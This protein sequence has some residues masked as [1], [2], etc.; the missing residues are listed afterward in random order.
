VLPT[1]QEPAPEAPPTRVNREQLGRSRGGLTPKI[2]LSSDGRARPL[3]LV[4]SEGQVS[5][6]KMLLPT[7]DAIGVPRLGRGRPRKR[8]D[9]TR[10]DKGYSYARCRKQ[11]RRRNLR[12]IIPERRDQRAQRSKKGSR[13]GRPVVFDKADYG[14]RNVVER[15]I[16]RL[17]QWRRVATRYDKRAINYRAFVTLAAIMLWLR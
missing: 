3:S 14:R 6:S 12:H 2:H 7:L 17:K 8:P 13:G 5:D 10:A 4:L 9:K 11:L 15:C 1:S 16:L